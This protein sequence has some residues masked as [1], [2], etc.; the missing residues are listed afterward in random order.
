M[1]KTEVETIR[2]NEFDTPWFFEEIDRI[3][4]AIRTR[5]DETFQSRSLAEPRETDVISAAERQMFFHPPSELI[6]HGPEFRLKIAAPGFQADQILVAVE[7]DCITVRGKVRPSAEPK[8]EKVIFSELRDRELFRRFP[9]AHPVD[10]GLVTAT[11]EDGLLTVILPKAAIA[12]IHPGEDLPVQL[13]TTA[14]AG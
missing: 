14:A 3:M 4:R 6:E 10:P 8:D 13:Q 7:P 12:L 2:P 9:L 11:L 1:R 5:A